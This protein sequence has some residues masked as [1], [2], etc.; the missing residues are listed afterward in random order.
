[1]TGVEW[2]DDR[3]NGS[4]RLPVTSVREL[5]DLLREKDTEDL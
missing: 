4:G 5:A 1:M 3:L 2:F